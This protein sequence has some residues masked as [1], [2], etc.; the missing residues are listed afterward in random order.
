[1]AKWEETCRRL[2]LYQL[3]DSDD[4]EESDTEED[5]ADDGNPDQGGG[6]NTD[7]D[8]PDDDQQ[9]QGDDRGGAGTGKGGTRKRKRQNDSSKSK[10]KA[11]PQPKRPR[12]P[13]DKKRTTDATSSYGNQLPIINTVDATTGLSVFSAT[14]SDAEKPTLLL[15][16][17]VWP[18]KAAYDTVAKNYLAIFDF[19]PSN[20]ALSII[21]Q[22]DDFTAQLQ[23][24]L[25]AILGVSTDGSAVDVRHASEQLGQ[26]FYPSPSIVPSL[27]QVIASNANAS[28]PIAPSLRQLAAV[29]LRKRIAKHWPSLSA[30]HNAAL[31]KTLLDHALS[32]PE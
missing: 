19:A 30:E 18:N 13:P 4:D 29:E 27:V 23:R 21:C 31:R 7:S 32:E 8:N 26:H 16:A 15:D 22:M 17:S 20:P 9:A 5:A 28:S 25:S 1:M 2:N 24:H 14:R 12:K 11:K 3:P 6:N 10:S